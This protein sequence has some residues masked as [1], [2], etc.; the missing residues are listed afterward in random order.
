MQSAAANVEWKPHVICP[1]C[2]SSAV[3][4]TRTMPAA[5]GDAVRVRYHR[6]RICKSL[7]KSVETR[8]NR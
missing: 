2:L 7:F 3:E 1:E 5:E 6:C 4:V 8:S